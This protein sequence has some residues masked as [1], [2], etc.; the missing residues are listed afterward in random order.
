MRQLLQFAAAS[1]AAIALLVAVTRTTH[2][3]GQ[4]AKPEEYTIKVMPP[5][6]P[7]P[8]LPN[9]KPDFSGHWLPNG[10]GQGISGRFGVDPDPPGGPRGSAL[11]PPER[12]PATE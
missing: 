11:D 1:M 8:R 2:A 9:G 12:D 10:A 3:Q 6:G 7:P 5:G 4:T